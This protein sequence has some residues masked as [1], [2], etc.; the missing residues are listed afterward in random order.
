MTRPND[1]IEQKTRSDLSRL[2]DFGSKDEVALSEPVD[3]VCPDLDLSFAPRQVDIGMMALVLGNG[4]GT[5]HEV[6]SGLEIRK[7]EFFFDVMIVH[8]VPIVDLSRQWF[9]LLGRQRWHATSARNTG[10]FSKSHNETSVQELRISIMLDQLARRMQPEARITVLTGAG[11]SAASGV[12]T[13]RGPDGLWKNYRPESLAT[14]EAFRRNPKL[15]WEWYD[16]RRQ[17]LS[18]K[19]PNRAHDV[20]AAWSRRYSTFTLITQNVDGLHEKAGTRNVIRF[21][22]SIWEVLCWDKCSASPPR[23]LDETV[24]FT[25][26][27]PSCPHCGGFIRPGV[28]WFGEGIDPDVMR[29]SLAALD[30]DVFFTVGTSSLVYPASSLVHEAKTRGAFTVE[31][32]VES[33]PASRSLDLALKAPAEEIL[34]AVEGRILKLDEL[35]LKSRNPKS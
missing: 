7:L 15:V 30:C 18:T 12:P 8:D 26:I 19:K 14:A 16:W 24:P 35:D 10:L 28:V 3:L 1:G 25:Q 21:H 33:T 4:A 31:V 2:I 9:D 13:F 6:E 20:L 17:V 34:D 29:Q 32:N 5:V 27:P 22:G 11:V 23:W